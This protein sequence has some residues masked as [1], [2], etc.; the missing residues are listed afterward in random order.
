MSDDW[1]IKKAGSYCLTGNVNQEALELLRK[2][3]IEDIK[4]LSGYVEYYNGSC[5]YKS[6]RP[7]FLFKIINK[8]FGVDSE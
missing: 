6:L 7:T 3:L 5:T 8:R 2:K 1:N 4:E